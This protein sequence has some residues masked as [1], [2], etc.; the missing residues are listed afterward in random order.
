MNV[1]A[2]ALIVPLSIAGWSGPIPA[3]GPEPA[4]LAAVAA[5]GASAGVSMGQAGASP[6]DATAPTL[7]QLIGQKLVVR[8]DGTTPSADLLGR[9]KRGEVGGVILLGFNITTRSALIALTGK[10]RAAAAAGGQP[11]L[12]IAVD[13]EG[14]SVKRIP[15]A[16]PTLSPPAMGR[17]ASTPTAREQGANTGAALHGLGIDV[18]F[19]PVADVPGSTASFMYQ[20][21]RTFSFNASRTAYLADA[22]ATGLESEGVIPTM[23]H[24]PG[25]GLATRNTDAYVVTIRASRT[26]LALGLRPYQRAIAH[27]IPLIMLS[28][29]TYTAYDAH[30]A[31]GWSRPIETLLRHDLGYTGATIT[32]SLDGTAKA[33]GLTSAHL[34]IRAAQAGTDMILITGSEATSRGVY[35]TLLAE[36]R[37]GSIATPTL[38]A[39]YDRILALKAGL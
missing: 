22:F 6:T 20:Q 14:G 12:L 32:D 25:I 5:A 17:L 33:R 24:F 3:P 21:G 19:A 13:Q 4:A 28:N 11:P 30:Y 15:W 10:L 29:A 38:R 34:A 23:K 31:A 7:A 1:L 36:A 26:A 16:P 18:D 39:S 37:S 35:A 2:L 27:H 9:I 8:M